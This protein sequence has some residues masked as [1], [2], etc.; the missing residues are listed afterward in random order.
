MAEAT[1]LIPILAERASRCDETDGF[2]RESYADLK[3]ARFFSA[4]IPVALGGGGASYGAV[5]DLVRLLAHGCSSTSLAFS[6]H[7]HLIAA[8]VW[9]REHQRAPV[10]DLLRRVARE[11]LVLVSSGGSD[12]L[13][14]SGSAHPVEGGFRI[15]ARKSFASGSPAGD[16]LMTTAV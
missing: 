6:M 10:D 3:R 4:G 9:K 5:C 2:V 12:W 14:S 11:Q 15:H 1:R 8:L 13:E 7:C 16:L